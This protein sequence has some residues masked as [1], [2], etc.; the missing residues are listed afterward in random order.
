MR[1]KVYTREHILKAAY[2]LINKEGFGNFTARNIAKHMGI[3]TQPIY[4]EFNNMQDLKNTLVEAVFKDLSENVFPVVRTGDK[5]VDLGLNYIH[6]AQ[7]KHNLYIALFID[8]YGGGEMMHEFSSNYFKSL[9]LSE[10][11]YNDLAEDTIEALHN[12]VWIVVTGIASLM[13]AGIIAPSEDQIIKVI[14]ETIQG[15]LAKTDTYIFNQ[16]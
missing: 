11:K 2:E 7:E 3:S 12:G 6:F 4:L 1:R 5:L 15:V 8:D 10:P 14:N 9:I 16:A 13:S